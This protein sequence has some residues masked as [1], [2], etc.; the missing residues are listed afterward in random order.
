MSVR[1]QTRI[2]VDRVEAPSQGVYQELLDIIA[3]IIAEKR[4]KEG[5]KCAREA[6]DGRQTKVRNLQPV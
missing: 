6:D 4:N 1:Y 2:T 5:R 3:E